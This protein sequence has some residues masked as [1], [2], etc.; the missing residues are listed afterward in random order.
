MSNTCRKSFPEKKVSKD[1]PLTAEFLFEATS[2]PGVYDAK[3]G[4][5]AVDFAKTM[6]VFC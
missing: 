3:C 1:S 2:Y 5:G 4:G 6:L